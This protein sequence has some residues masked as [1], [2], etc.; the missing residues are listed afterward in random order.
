MA[1]QLDKTFYFILCSHPDGNYAIENDEPDDKAA[2]L[3]TVKE[4]D[5]RIVTISAFNTIE[6]WARDV[7]EDFAREYLNE[8]IKAGHPFHDNIPEFIENVIGIYEA[9]GLRNASWAAAQQAR[10]DLTASLH[11]SVA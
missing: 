5:G 3:A 10:R 4:L 2:T 11:R 8:L 9:E 1:I 6:G 7:T